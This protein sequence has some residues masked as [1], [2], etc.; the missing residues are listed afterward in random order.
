MIAP[1]PGLRV[2]IALDP[3]DFRKGAA[4]LAALVQTALGEDAFSRTIYVFRARRSELEPQPDRSTRT[5]PQRAA[6]RGN[7]PKDLPRVEKLVDLADKSCPC[8]RRE[9]VCI[10]EDRAERLDVVPAQLRVEVTIRPK[11]T[12]RS[13]DAARQAPSNHVYRRRWR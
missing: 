8:C 6:N 2:M 1:S 12:C 13:C 5:K 3:V 7:L 11:Y 9:M 4:G 10:G